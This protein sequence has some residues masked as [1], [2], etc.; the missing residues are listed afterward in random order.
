MAKSGSIEILIQTKDLVSVKEAAEA[1][2]IARVT[3]YKQISRGE[4][5]SCRLGGS[6]YVPRSEV[7][8]IL[9]ERGVKGV[10]PTKW[11]VFRKF[12]PSVDRE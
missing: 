1:L 8:R 9:K 10:P 11:A 7:E 6:L 3:V 2:G 5:L 4:L 12:K